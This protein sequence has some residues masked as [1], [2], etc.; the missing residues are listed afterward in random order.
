MSSQVTPRITFS[1]IL[2]RDIILVSH[3]EEKSGDI[4]RDYSALLKRVRDHT[5]EIPVS[6]EC[7]KFTFSEGDGYVKNSCLCNP[8]GSLH[9]YN[10]PL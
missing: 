7:L 6:E 9:L 8:S 10:R 4:Q 5:A 3:Q 1:F 2:N